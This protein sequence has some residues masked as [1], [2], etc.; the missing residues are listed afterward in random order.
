M[1]DQMLLE[2]FSQFGAENFQ[3]LRLFAR[4]LINLHNLFINISAEEVSPLRRVLLC[5]F[6]FFQNLANIAILALLDRRDLV[7]HVL[8]QVLHKLLGLLIAVHALVYLHADHLAKFVCYL[9]LAALEPINLILDRV[10]DFR[11]FSAQDDFL[12]GSGHLFLPDPAVDAPDLSLQV[13][14]KRL[15]GLVF[16]LELIADIC[17]HLVVALTHLL[18]TLSALFALHALFKVHLVAH[19]IDLSGSLLLL[20]KQAIDEVRDLDLQS[21]LHIVLQSGYHVPEVIAI[22]E[23]GDLQSAEVLLLLSL[24]HA[25]HVHVLLEAHE[26]TLDALEDLIEEHRRGVALS[27]H[28]LVV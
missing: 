27:V 11:H 21:V 5:L 9:E 23:I 14:V 10:I 28:H 12:L 20:A 26:F 7:H 8:E 13:R 24:L 17:I 19:V 2:L 15:D 18:N 6:D 1:I 16:A 22:L 25:H 3:V 4:L